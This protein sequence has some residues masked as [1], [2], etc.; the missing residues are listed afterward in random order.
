M[1]ADEVAEISVLADAMSWMFLGRSTCS[2]AAFRQTWALLV[3]YAGDVI[4]AQ[5]LRRIFFVTI[6]NL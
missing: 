5:A 1:W 4:A 2:D 3:C 6:S